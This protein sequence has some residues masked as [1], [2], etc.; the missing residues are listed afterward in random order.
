VSGTFKSYQ[1]RDPA[2]VEC[3]G[4]VL[5]NTVWTPNHRYLGSDVGLRTQRAVAWTYARPVR[6]GEVGSVTVPRIVP[7][8][9]NA[10]SCGVVGNGVR[11]AYDAGWAPAT[12]TQAELVDLWRRDGLARR[13]GTT[14]RMTWHEGTAF[15]KTFTLD[16][17]TLR[18]DYT[19]VTPGHVV[20][21]EV[22]VDLW[23]GAHE[24]RLLTRAA[25]AG[26]VTVAMAGAGAARIAAGTG[27]ELTAASRAETVEQAAAQGL[28]TEFL[29]LHRVLTEAVQVRATAPEFSYAVDL[30]A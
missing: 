6:A 16:G 8:N 20:D 9:F 26:G 29:T 12:T 10:Y 15:A 21:N 25:D 19:G 22:C 7:D 17:T 3:D 13:T 23:A 28:A 14:D 1:Y 30:R 2:G 18:V 24:G 5:Q 27:C 11:C 4:H